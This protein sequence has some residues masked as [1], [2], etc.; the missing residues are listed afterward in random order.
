MDAVP[1]PIQ[2]HGSMI[3]EVIQKI[4]LSIQLGS[5][6]WEREPGRHKTC[7]YDFKIYFN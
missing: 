4:K 1:K 5:L 3:D 6:K 7:P 2:L